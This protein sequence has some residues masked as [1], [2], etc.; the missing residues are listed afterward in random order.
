MAEKYLLSSAYLPPVE[1]MV[2]VNA[3][4]EILIEREENYL[5]QT[6]RNRCY[7]L[8]ANGPMALSVPVLLGSSH[9]TPIKDIR[10]DYSK[11]WQQVHIRALKS[12][13]KSSA[14]YEYYFDNFE[15]IILSNYRFL[16]DFN[17]HLLESIL[18]ISGVKTSISYTTFFEPASGSENDFRYLISP[19]EQSGTSRIRNQ[20]YY[21]V[22]ST[23][24]GFVPGLS[25]IDLI[26]NLGPDA[27]NYLRTAFK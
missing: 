26:F 1:Y 4:D 20:E 21:Q 23:K 3:A 25:V 15:K 12:S 10:I 11:K 17:M 18:K 7:I 5:K 9:K 2:L 6:Y 13:Y 27:S 24:S 16:L 8:S 14:F 22:F 19:K